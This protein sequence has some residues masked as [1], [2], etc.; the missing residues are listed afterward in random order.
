VCLPVDQ[1]AEHSAGLSLDA[2]PLYVHTKR[3]VSVAI[4]DGCNCVASTYGVMASLS[5]RYAHRIQFLG[6]LT[7]NETLIYPNTDDQTLYA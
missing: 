7:H 4:E 5:R 1:G 2:N 6:K 3:M